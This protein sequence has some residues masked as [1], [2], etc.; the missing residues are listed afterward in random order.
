MRV[1]E[2]SVNERILIHLKDFSMDPETEG[3]SLGQTQE[4][5]GEAV[6]IRI[7][8]VPR[9]TSS[10]MD[11]GYIGE[12]L[13]HIGGLKRKRKAF[14]LTK[15]G[16]ET[17]NNL[18]SKL[19]TQK[20][21]FR[22]SNGDEKKLTIPE[23][24][25][26]ARNSTFS[27]LLLTFFR[28]GI[29]LQSSLSGDKSRMHISLL[30]NLPEPDNYVNRV[31]EMSF[32]RD[33][34]KS[35]E[36]LIIVSGIKGIG[37]T[38]LVWKTLKEFESSK[39]IFW[40]TAHEWD[41]TRSILEQFSEFYIRLARG[42]VKKALRLSRDIDIGQ[43]ISALLKDVRDSDSI[44]VIDNIFDLKKEVMQLLCMLC[45]QSRN[46]DN[47]CLILI[48]R[49]RESLGMTPS[50]Q[51][52]GRN[53]LVVKGLER[54][55]AMGLMESMGMEPEDGD[56]VYAMTQGHPLAIKLVNSEE[57]MKVI[58]TKGLTKEEVWVVRC[59]KAFD[60]IFE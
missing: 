41:T 9:A 1:E 14:Y 49:D 38:S 54:V 60:A 59:L 58:D 7:N 43:S 50:L 36:K 46:L 17:S 27:G 45:E 32:I 48:T 20:V 53:D 4:G 6:G 39:N 3:A 56:R 13:M 21:I 25:F 33:M 30:D 44:L 37:K 23:I 16:F 12:I 2:L 11:D 35:G 18:I 31:Q 22:D 52:M 5:I 57:I 34:V 8:H 29:I 10:L 28:D 55:S 42:E 51:H 40:Y 47:S 19:E 15:K 24:L 26:T